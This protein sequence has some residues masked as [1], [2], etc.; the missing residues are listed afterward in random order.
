MPSDPLPG[1]G[2]AVRTGNLRRCDKHYIPARFL[3]L[4]A[5]LLRSERKTE[6][7][8]GRSEYFSSAELI[9]MKKCDFLYAHFVHYIW[10]NDFGIFGLICDT[11]RSEKENLFSTFFQ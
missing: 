11:A 9:N 4:R 7:R 8:P 10:E 6:G 2:A 3:P 1:L 5:R